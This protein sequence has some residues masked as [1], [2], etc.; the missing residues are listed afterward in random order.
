MLIDEEIASLSAQYTDID[1]AKISTFADFPLSKKTLEGLKLNNYEK[2]TEIQR[3]T[4]GLAL[5]GKDIL[6]AAKTGSGKT[7]AFLIPILELLY[8][9]KW[10]P[11]DGLG[12]LIISPTRELAYQTFEVLRKIG[13]KHDFSAGLVIGGKHLR[14]ESERISRTNIVVCTP[15]R[16]LQHMD[17]TVGFTAHSLKILVLD[18][19]DRILDLG[20]AQTMNAVVENLPP[21][22]Q[23]LLFSATQTKSV[24]DL[25]RLSLHQPMFVSVHELSEYSTPAQLEQSYIVCELHEKLNILWSFVKNHMKS[26][27]LV[28]F[29]SC[30]QVKFV[31][32][33]FKKLR[34]GLT[35]LCLHGGMHQ[36]K[37]VAMYDQFC[38]KKHAVLF[39]T[40]IAAR[41]L[42]FPA[43]NWV[44]QL[45]CPEDANTYIHR[46]GRTA[47]YEK[48]GESLL[49]LLPSEEEEMIRQLESK[50]IPIQ[51]MKPNPKRIW[52]VQN[53]LESLC[54]SDVPLKDSA[55]RAFVSYLRSV[56]LMHNKKVFDVHKLDTEAFSRSLGLA[57][58]PRV[59]FL[60][61]D[62]KR[63]ELKK[64]EAEKEKSGGAG[65]DSG[66]V[67]LAKIKTKLV[68]SESNDESDDES[69]V[70][71]T[72]KRR[73]RDIDYTRTKKSESESDASS[74]DLESDA[75][76]ESSQSDDSEQS[77]TKRTKNTVAK[78]KPKKTD[79]VSLN[80]YV[81]DNE[82]F[83][84]VKNT[85]LPESDDDDE[86]GEGEEKLSK[87]KANLKPLT[88]AA[89]AKKI[90]K[91]KLKVNSKIVFD[92]EGEAVQDVLKS[93]LVSKEIKE[94]EEEVV[95]EGGINI[96]AAKKLMKLQDQVDK[97]IFR[98]RVKKMHR[99]KRLKQKELRRE[100]EAQ[101]KGMQ[102][103]LGGQDSDEGEEE[104]EG[105]VCLN[106]KQDDDSD[107]SFN[108]E[109][110]DD[111]GG[112]DRNVEVSGEVESPEE[113]E[114]SDDEEDE[115]SDRDDESGDDESNDDD[116]SGSDGSDEDE[117]PQ[118]K[119]RRLEAPSGNKSKKAWQKL[120]KSG[121]SLG[122]EEAL[123]LKLLQS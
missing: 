57:I 80:F 61:R 8:Q 102:V 72:P 1:S 112:E 5:Q 18:E 2:P 29:Q 100:K 101:K 14:E 20:F 41:G 56:F 55:Q 62:Q 75:S 17:E 120:D 16:L 46:A 15:G 63:L 82:D 121:L 89:A 32:E 21:E 81:D 96:E 117:R 38:R 91:K 27:I 34:T 90:L 6:G 35:T 87:K 7:L 84:Q 74:E 49:I 52:S 123:A 71:K 86:D 51:K 9:N 43:V 116:E 64:A 109:D 19:A 79:D 23:T 76:S 68:E 103:V 78:L 60:Q 39:A 65:E 114:Q 110:Y 107:G 122:D 94:M 12:A 115:D 37:R 119:K 88:K 48:D 93:G 106:Q 83:L 70:K 97:K 95:T 69:E 111:Y 50:K 28:F 98:E 13:K 44:I 66:D 58:P 105:E 59:R 53:R 118:Q 113:N 77:E 3:E 40:D 30:K 67:L 92:D 85:S 36:L 11:L 99:E 26:K 42:D 25:A 22:R 10:S 54:A 45:D 33:V 4:V 108:S 31:Y 73:V 24:K 47:R 104:G